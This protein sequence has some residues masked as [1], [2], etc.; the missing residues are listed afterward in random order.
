MSGKYLCSEHTKCENG[1]NL[2]HKLTRF[3]SKVSERKSNEG[4]KKLE[5]NFLRGKKSIKQL[6]F[7][8]KPFTFSSIPAP[9]TEDNIKSENVFLIC[10]YI[11]KLGR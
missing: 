1:V 6:Q 8:V 5:K 2:C 11:W 4:R 3:E 9:K 10:I 7:T